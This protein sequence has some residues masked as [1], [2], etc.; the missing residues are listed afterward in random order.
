MFSS[1][2]T[3]GLFFPSGPLIAGSLP[4]FRRNA[5]R[6]LLFAAML[7]FHGTLLPAQ[8]G[9]WTWMGGSTGWI[10]A[11][12]T[13][14][15]ALGV[16]SA[17]FSPGPRQWSATWTGADGS[18]WLFGGLGNDATGSPGSLNDLWRFAPATNEWTWMS[19]SASL[20]ASGAYGTLN[21]P[22]AANT[23]GARYQAVTWVDKSGNL[24]LFGGWGYDST[25][26]L[27]YLNDLWIY[28]VATNQWTWKGGSN[29]ANQFS[30]F[31]A[32]GQSSASYIPG[33]R[34]SAMSWVDAS[35]NFWLFGGAGNY[36]NTSLET[37]VALNDLW[38]YSPS[39]G[40]WTW[41]GG[42]L[43]ATYGTL[44]HPAPGNWPGERTAGATW[45]D[46]NGTLW[47]Y[48]GYGADG[49]ENIGV[50]GD[51]WSLNPANQQWTWVSGPSFSNATGDYGV[52]GVAAASNYAPNRMY[53]NVWQDKSGNFWIFGGG[54][55]N[56]ANEEILLNDVWEYTPA[57]N[58]WT[59][60]AG[61]PL[62]DV[63]QHAANGV[64]GTLGTPDAANIPGG[65]AAAAN[66]TGQQGDFWLYGGLYGQFIN[67]G[68]AFQYGS[69]DDLWIYSPPVPATVP[70]AV[71]SPLQLSFSTE[72][73]TIASA[74]TVTLGNPGTGTLTINSIAIG[75]ANASDFSQ[76]NTCGT[77]LAAGASCTITVS[78]APSGGGFDVAT[79]AVTDSA[80]TTLPI[81]L[82]GIALAQT[83]LTLSATPASTSTILAPVKLTATLAPASDSAASTNGE[84][85]IF[86][87]GGK[88]L[89][90]GTLAGGIATLTTTQIPAGTNSLTAAYAGDT[91]FTPSTSS[92]LTFTVTDPT[93]LT[94]TQ[95]TLAFLVNGQPVTSA[96]RTSQ[97]NLTATVT[98]SGS[99]VT[100]GIVTFCD[101]AYAACVGQGFI[102]IAQ[103]N[104]KGIATLPMR[105]G[106]GAH[107]IVARFQVQTRLAA[108]VSPI[109]S[110]SINNALTTASL[111]S[112]GS[113]AD[114][115]LTATITGF[116]PKTAPTGSVQFI[117]T[118]N[119]NA[120]LGA[121]PL[122][123]ATA[124]Q[125]WV[126][127]PEIPNTAGFGWYTTTADLNGDGIPDII[128]VN[129][130]L[131]EALSSA[132]ES[133]QVYLG[134]G[135]GTFNALTPMTIISGTPSGTTGN[136]LF[137]VASISMGDFNQDGIP[138]LA[139]GLSQSNASPSIV[140]LL[141][142]GD[143]TFT[144]QPAQLQTTAG[145]VLLA[146]PLVADFNGDGIPDIL[147]TWST[148]SY[149]T[150][151]LFLGKGDGTFQ[152]ASVATPI[153]I[154]SSSLNAPVYFPVAADFNGDGIPDV[155]FATPTDAYSYLN[156]GNGTFNPVQ[157]AVSYPSLG[158]Y[159]PDSYYIPA[160]GDFNG[161]G[162]PDLAVTTVD[163]EV[164]I[165]LGNGDGT[166]NTAVPSLTADAESTNL[167]AADFAGNGFDGLAS[168]NHDGTIS[169]FN[170]NGDGTFTPQ[171]VTIG[172][173][174][175][176]I[177]TSAIYSA[178]IVAGDFHNS[179]RKDLVVTVAG[180]F[181]IQT[182]SNQLTETATVNLYNV[183]LTGTGTH[184]IVAVYSGDSL[185]ATSTSSS[186]ALSA[187]SLNTTNTSLTV[188]PTQANT[189]VSVTLSGT[190]A[191]ASGSTTPTG[192]I[193][194][195]D[196]AGILATLPVNTSG[197]TS[198]SSTLFAAGK[199]NLTAVYSGDASN[200][201]STSPA[202]TLTVSNPVPAAT[203][204]PAGPL[205]FTTAAGTS[206]A[207]QTVT[208]SNSGGA[209]LSITGIAITGTNASSFGQSNNCGATLVAG[210]NCSI[211]VT[212]SPTAAGSDSASLTVSDNAS[213]SPQSVSLSGSA[214]APPSFTVSS[215]T[216]PQTVAEGGSATYTITVTPQNGAYDNAVTF[217]A[218][219]LPTGATA[220]FSPASV[221]PG[222]SAIN[223]TL[224][225][226]APFTA[227]AQRSFPWPVGVPVVALSGLL[228]LP[229][230]MRRR[231]IVPV[232][233]LAASLSS[234]LALT[235]CGGGFALNTSSPVTYNITVT[236][237]S[238]SIQQSTTVQLTVAQR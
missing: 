229:R 173:G 30:V 125:S 219:S 165:L 21:S 163:Q 36:V 201:A 100:P 233:L 191:P 217:T 123:G 222:S 90:T 98:S 29:L 107:Q 60:V 38:M 27:G 128:V 96:S 190:V 34:Y 68:V 216:G 20:S 133:I 140:I 25:G 197:T 134:N 55:V 74:Q 198:F 97:V 66:W 61:T 232:V 192:D 121:V 7:S 17:Q 108:S 168:A 106:A 203:F 175:P 23:P 48:G 73:G 13:P 41:Y 141:G 130:E 39:S 37:N 149:S 69:Y 155:A 94:A 142:K 88:Y 58:Q 170:S 132:P 18:F 179:G 56:T 19:G 147:A 176:P 207:V 101:A 169:I 193:S 223:S 235:G 72:A 186:V 65:R 230:R 44:G 70:E 32:P 43:Q 195:F 80:A 158:I 79:L 124:N 227:S 202:V 92:A 45:V 151:N 189:G 83:T 42:E 9:D 113:S 126:V 182:I 137:D 82:N 188:T 49:L 50:L 172:N 238:G 154:F 212:F 93:N 185:F 104:S 177:G 171:V 178:G 84:A 148:D 86:W 78:F 194:F 105:F 114:Y 224:T 31:G 77:S 51:L 24:W 231:W 162:K 139:V 181:A 161:D 53:T 180:N 220:T 63:S 144:V 221:T 120:V 199:H 35:G 57:A 122:T 131:N 236:A 110:I 95:T 46:A 159:L 145:S 6:A 210:S 64:Y 206:S 116:G 67:T 187:D 164:P 184:N 81:A 215:S 4:R 152:L 138:D 16:P 102:G 166:F 209:T 237:T 87:E 143:G 5:A 196:G 26:T 62:A 111:T 91:N 103:T 52:L 146:A 150:S 115:Q 3:T 14:R 136:S 71:L 226:A 218:S 127:G 225:I 234:A 10:G 213:G 167:V 22:A 15:G 33:S 1:I 174:T 135:D 119:N 129:G 153:G 118:S 183:R 75:G 40:A 54:A 112:S 12:P 59:W 208:L 76:T 156:Y 89:G 85:I 200:L 205:S 109:T 160:V 228:L 99:P 47:L 117:D 204:N 214:T 11:T 2:L 157:T 211:S 8:A 28:D